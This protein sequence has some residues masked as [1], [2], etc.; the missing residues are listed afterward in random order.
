M[1]GSGV[2]T[3]LCIDVGNNATNINPVFEGGLIPYA[4][5][6]TLAGAQIS[7]YIRDRFTARELDLGGD[8][9][10][11]IEGTLFTVEICYYLENLDITIIGFSLMILIPSLQNFCVNYGY[12]MNFYL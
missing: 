8:T 2:A 1:Y 5:M 7:S 10:K 9:D 11:T 6:Q 12:I 4:H 3:G